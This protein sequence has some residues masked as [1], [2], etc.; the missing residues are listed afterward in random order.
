MVYADDGVHLIA[1]YGPR[2]G[3]PIPVPGDP[4]YLPHAAKQV[5]TLAG[6]SP[7]QMTGPVD[8]NRGA[9]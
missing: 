1:V 6:H 3:E 5:K 9:W 7:G 8:T 4:D 2:K